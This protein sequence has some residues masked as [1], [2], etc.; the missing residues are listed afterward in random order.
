[1]IKIIH[2]KVINIFI[3]KY[4]LLQIQFFT[5][6]KTRFKRCMKMKIKAKKFEKQI[7]ENF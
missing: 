1:M 5:Y 6:K 7:K 3:Y 2:D 4:K